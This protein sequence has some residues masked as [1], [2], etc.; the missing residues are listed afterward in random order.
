MVGGES[1][2]QWKQEDKSRRQKQEEKPGH[3][4][5]TADDRY[6]MALRF[7]SMLRCQQHWKLF[8]VVVSVLSEVDI[9]SFI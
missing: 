5:T 6:A 2:R 4:A 7:L 1:S 3:D 8:I 9:P